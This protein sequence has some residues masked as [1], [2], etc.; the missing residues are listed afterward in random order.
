MNGSRRAGPPTDPLRLRLASASPRR[1]RL[2]PLLG[3]PVEGVATD[4][5][6]QPRPGERPGDLAL[7][8]AAEKAAAAGPPGPG[9]VVV[10]SDTDVALDGRVLGKPANA[11]AARRMLRAL[12]GRSH[13]VMSGV[14]LVAPGG[15][16]ATT[17]ATTVHMRDYSDH[18]IDAYVAS[19]RPLDKA[20]AYAIQDQDFGPVERIDGCYLNVV[21][22]PLCEVSRG[23]R[24]LGWPLPAERFDPPCR[25]CA[26]GRAAL[27]E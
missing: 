4:V 2:L 22:L 8:L 10:G 27:E 5:D 3:Y 6:E 24:A 9:E 16:Y 12:R 17:I 21:G 13:G 1:R 23:L 26:L 25:L 19:G 7:R 18:A 14:A 20:G 11:E 15:S